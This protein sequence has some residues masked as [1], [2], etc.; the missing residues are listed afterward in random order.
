MPAA[1]P[2]NEPVT[3]AIAFARTFESDV[4]TLLSLASASTAGP[5]VV[6]ADPSGA[7]G[8]GCVPD[9]V[10][11]TVAFVPGPVAEVDPLEGPPGAVE[12]ELDAFIGSLV[13][14]VAGPASPP[15]AEADPPTVELCEPGRRSGA[16][17]TAG[18]SASARVPA[19]LRSARTATISISFLIV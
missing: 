11:G 7:D 14:T 6:G 3:V 9:A 10:V 1:D 8:S 17:E 13:A 19:T 12:F 18:L 15:L 5:D 2:A 4:E 16:A